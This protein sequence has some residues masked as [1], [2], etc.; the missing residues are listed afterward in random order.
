MGDEDD[1]SKVGDGVKGDCVVELYGDVAM[2]VTGEM[3]GDKEG[4]RDPPGGSAILAVTTTMSFWPFLH[5]P[6]SPLMK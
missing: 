3:D 5:Q 2:E 4:A 6:A 1:P